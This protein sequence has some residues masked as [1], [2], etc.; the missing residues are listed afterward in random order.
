MRSLRAA[1]CWRVDV[2]KGGRGWRWTSF[3]STPTTDSAGGSAQDPGGALGVFPRRDREFAESLAVEGREAGRKRRSVGRAESRFDRPV[4]P[5]LEDL[6][7]QLAFADQAQRD[8]LHATG[9]AR[10]GEFAPEHRRQG[11]AHQVVERPSGLLGVDEIH[12]EITRVCDGL[13]NGAAGHLVEDD[14]LDLHAVHG[15]AFLERLEHVPRDG[16]AF[17]VGIGGPDT[18]D[19]RSAAP[20][21]SR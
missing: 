17:A 4:L 8:R 7:L 6:D 12:V 1:S 10:A 18:G 19:R 2:V 3:A 16:F 15:V 20:A 21:R 13:P 5:R 11:E 9:R 14:P